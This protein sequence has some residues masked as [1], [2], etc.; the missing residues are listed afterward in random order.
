VAQDIAGSHISLQ[1]WLS[2]FGITILVVFVSFMFSVGI[3]W[4]IKQF[5]R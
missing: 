2:G 3:R 1:D 4:S 5:K